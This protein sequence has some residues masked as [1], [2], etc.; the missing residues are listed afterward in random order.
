MLTGSRLKCCGLGFPRRMGRVTHAC[1]QPARDLSAPCQVC[2]ART[3]S[4]HPESGCSPCNAPMRDVS[5]GTIPQLPCRS[6][7]GVLFPR[8]RIGR[9][10][11]RV[12]WLLLCLCSALSLYSPWTCSCPNSVVLCKSHRPQ[13]SHRMGERAGVRVFVTLVTFVSVS[14]RS[15]RPFPCIAWRCFRTLLSCALVRH[16]HHR[17]LCRRHVGVSL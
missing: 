3:L 17:L 8:P 4:N 5:S 1:G 2:D 9:K 15:A 6:L 16:R 10:N 7:V 11:L 12:S 13:L 14:P